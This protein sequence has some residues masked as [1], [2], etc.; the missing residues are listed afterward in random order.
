MN[1]VSIQKQ[2]S[3]TQSVGK[4][5]TKPSDHSQ[6]PN[7]FIR[8]D[9]VRNLLRLQNKAI[10]EDTLKV[11]LRIVL[12]ATPIDEDLYLDRYPDVAKAV[13]SGVYRSAREHLTTVGYFEGRSA[14]PDQFDETAYL[15]A[16]PDVADAVAS[17]SLRSAF[18]HFTHSG[19]IEGRLP[20]PAV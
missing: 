16:Y 9:A 14:W 8:Y 17:G 6:T 3:M 2:A 20:A 1:A 10:A 5:M 12:D 18:E 19:A 13:A 11:I 4:P 7:Y 15:K